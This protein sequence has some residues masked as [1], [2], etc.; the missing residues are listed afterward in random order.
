M[1]TDG[2]YLWKS[3]GQ[4]VRNVFTLRSAVNDGLI[5]RTGRR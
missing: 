5:F 3:L 1:M 4:S 2:S